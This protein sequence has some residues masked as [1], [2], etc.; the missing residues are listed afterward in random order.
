LL[1][2]V[3]LLFIVLLLLHSLLVLASHFHVFGHL[4]DHSHLLL[5]HHLE[6]GVLDSLDLTINSVDFELVSMDL[7][8][9]ILE[10]SNHLLK[11]LGA[12]FEVL[13]V[14][15]EFFSDFGTTLLGQNIFQLDVKFLFFLDKD[16]LLRDLFG[17]R[18]KSFLE[19]LDF[20][21]KLIGLNI[22]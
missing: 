6:V 3:L 14:N 8:L 1:L 19:R 16:I 22:S 7:T 21:N 15:N 17:L 5:S 2:V 20:L 11:L 9:V 18:N 12:L 13:L 10:F 4:W